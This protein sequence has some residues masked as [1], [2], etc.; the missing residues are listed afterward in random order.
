MYESNAE[1]YC[2]KEHTWFEH[3]DAEKARMDTRSYLQGLFLLEQF[4]K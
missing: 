1:G 3:G 2:T 4:K